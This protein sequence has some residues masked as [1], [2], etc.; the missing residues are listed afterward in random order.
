MDPQQ[1]KQFGKQ[2]MRFGDWIVTDF[3]LLHVYP[4]YFIPKEELWKVWMDTA[5]DKWNWPIHVTEKA[6]CDLLGMYEFNHA[7]QYAQEWFHTVKPSNMPPVS[8][9]KTLEFQKSEFE[10]R[11]GYRTT[12]SQD[13]R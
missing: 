7:F 4:E 8:I 13:S 12:D 6:W 9:C 1:E 3:G 2:V 5:Q 10:R 11:Q